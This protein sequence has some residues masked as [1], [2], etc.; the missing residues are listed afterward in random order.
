MK[1]KIFE[2]TRGEKFTFDEVISTIDQFIEEDHDY[3]YNLMIGCDSQK[4]G[5]VTR[6]VT[7]VI[8]YRVTKASRIFFVREKIHNQLPIHSRLFQE[9]MESVELVKALEGTDIL[10]KV[11]SCEVHIDAGGS[12]KTEGVLIDSIGYVTSLGFE[13]IPKPDSFAAFTCADHLVRGKN[14]PEKIRKRNRKNDR[15]GNK[16]A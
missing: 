9:T 14:Q 7:V 13:A 6:F 15:K 11:D 8:I 1:D 16:T 4:M 2:N 3:K 5:K 10:Y 12:Q